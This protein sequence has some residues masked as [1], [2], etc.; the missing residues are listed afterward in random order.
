MKRRL[1]LASALAVL[2]SHVFSAGSAAAAG[3]TAYCPM[4]ED[5]CGA[6]LKAFK[7]DTGVESQFVRIGA[8]EIKL[9]GDVENYV[10]LGR[11]A[12]LTVRMGETRITAQAAC[13]L[14]GF[15]YAWYRPDGRLPPDAVVRELTQ[16]AG[17]V[18][19]LRPA[20]THG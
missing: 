20:G 9:A 7:D 11:E 1:A 16:L 12:H 4:S 5:D 10:Y 14:P 8:G 2:C 3:L 19:G 13:S 18:L 6:V 15:L 17:R